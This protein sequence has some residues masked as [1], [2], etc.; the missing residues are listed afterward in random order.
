[1]NKLIKHSR[2]GRDGS[3]GFFV[4][5][6]TCLVAALL[7]LCW[8]EKNSDSSFAFATTSPTEDNFVYSTKLI[9]DIAV[10]DLV[11]AR[12]P[13]TGEVAQKRVVH[14]F[15]RTSDHLRILEIESTDGEVQRIETTD[16]HP[17]W[18]TGHGFVN[19]GE[20]QVG[21]QLDD[22]GG[23]NGAII[24]SSLRDDHPDGIQVCNFEV[25]DFH[26][27]F[28]RAGRTRGPP[29][30]VH[31]AE[32]YEQLRDSLGRFQSKTGTELPPGGAAEVA[33]LARR[34]LAKNTSRIPSASGAAEFR[35]PDGLAANGRHITEIKNVDSLALTSQ[36]LDDVSF[37]TRKGGSGVVDVVIDNRTRVSQ[38][39]LDAHL[40]SR[41]PI[42]LIRERLR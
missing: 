33:A 38:P 41:S 37:V 21:D 29:L 4:M 22:A 42:N 27:Y 36:L 39:L 13:K 40:D 7:T 6:A 8:A 15:R 5:A 32:C 2:F 23:A 24:V 14:A 9:E 31:N 10:G 3:T 1:M 11:M 18:V 17:F 28:V 16:E 19:A 34:G 35:I 25:E 26:T 30:Y 20:L 12:D